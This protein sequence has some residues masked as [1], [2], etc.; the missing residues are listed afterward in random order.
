MKAAAGLGGFFSGVALDLIRFPQDLAET[1]ADIT[2]APDVV[3]KLGLV[4]G[5]LPAVL[6]IAGAIM[7]LGYRISRTELAHIQREIAKSALN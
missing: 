6:G 1:G 4:H 3:T 5:P 2:L 7:L